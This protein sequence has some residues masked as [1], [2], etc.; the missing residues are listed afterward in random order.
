VISWIEKKRRAA[1]RR[2]LARA[3]LGLAGCTLLVSVA[4]TFLPV[5]HQ[6]RLLGSLDRPP[7]AVYRVLTDLDALPLWRSDLTTIERLPDAAGRIIWREGTTSGEQVVE[8][9]ES[10]PPH[11]L[12]IRRLVRGQAMLPERTFDLEPTARGTLVRLTERTAVRSPLRR[13]LIRVSGSRDA[14]VLLRDLEQRI[15]LNRSHV[16]SEAVTRAGH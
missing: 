13:V 2:A 6:I 11:R 15:N 10:R 8:L 4:G 14:G 12:V 3:A 16:A 7:E 9:S 1:R 5:E